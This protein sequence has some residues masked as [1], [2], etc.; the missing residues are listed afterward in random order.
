MR[1]DKGINRLR[2]FAGA[3]LPDPTVY[4]TGPSTLGLLEQRNK[5]IAH[6]KKK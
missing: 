6:L 1:Y 4:I 5:I 2:V 3:L